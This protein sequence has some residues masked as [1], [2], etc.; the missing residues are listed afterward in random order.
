MNF[1]SFVIFVIVLSLYY[2][3]YV[4]VMMQETCAL[5]DIEESPYKKTNGSASSSRSHHLLL[6][7]PCLYETKVLY[8]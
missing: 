7:F 2:K 1:L 4:Y 6:H 5:P 3:I 8:S